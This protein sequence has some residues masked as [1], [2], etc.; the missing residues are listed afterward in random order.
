MYYREVTGSTPTMSKSK[1]LKMEEPKRYEKT[2]VKFPRPVYIE[3]WDVVDMEWS[4]CQ[5]QYK[6]G[7]HEAM[8]ARNVEMMRE[9]MKDDE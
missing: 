1:R 6:A 5:V 4:Y 3:R 8:N 2:V 9:R 7:L